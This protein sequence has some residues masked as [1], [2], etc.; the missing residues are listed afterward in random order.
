MSRWNLAWMLGVPAIVVLGI[1]LAYSAPRRAAREQDY[2]LVKLVVDVLAEVDQSY[3]KELN[4]EQKRKLVEDMING[5][6]ERL[7]P[8]SAYMNID[9]YR[10]FEQQSEGSFGGV[11]IN[12]GIDR[13][14]GL[15]QVVSPMVG[16]PAYEAGVLA[17]DLIVKVDGKS[18]ENFRISDAIKAIQGEPGTPITLTV[19]HDGTK[20]QVDLTMKRAK[21]EVPSILG[22]VRKPENPR[23]WDWFVDKASKI[24]YVRMIAFTEHTT[25]DIKKAL[26]AMEAEGVRGLVLDLRD[27]PGGLLTTA[28]EVAD[29]FIGDGAIVS[30]RD[31]N[32]NGRTYSARRGDGRFENASAYPMTVLI[33]KNS[34]SASEIVSAALQDHGR[35]TVI[36]E[37]SY[38]KGSV[39]NIIRLPDR[40]PPTA[41]KLTT[42]S[43]WRPSGKNIHRMTD[44]KETDEWGVKPSAGFEVKLDDKERFQYLVWRRQRDIIPGKVGAAEKRDDKANKDEKPFTDRVLNTA[45]EQLRKQITQG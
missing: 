22:D 25:A 32:G 18:T 6:L 23:E 12:V 7:D 26:A 38:G 34:A 16:T 41:V 17:G 9:E 39:Q 44:S 45:V 24:G 4:A 13:T 3:V 5:G 19:I 40:V 1:T 21:I 29:L 15:L 36:G 37:R 33:N 10:H 2:E 31:R 8:Y 35:A 43:Y 27:N 30:T 42:A 20:E 14:T 11:G 28:V